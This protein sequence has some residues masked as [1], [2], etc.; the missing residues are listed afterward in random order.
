MTRCAEVPVAHIRA[1]GYGLDRA[2]RRIH[3]FVLYEGPQTVFVDDMGTVF[4]APD[5]CITERALMAGHV[6][7]CVGR[8]ESNSTKPRA[9][10]ATRD[11][12]LENLRERAGELR[13]VAA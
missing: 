4:A 13:K 3:W 12:I 10:Q 5:G 9:F 7:W 6:D 1:S 8:F 11:L 2:T